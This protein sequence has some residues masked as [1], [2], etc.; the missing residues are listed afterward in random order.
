MVQL[1]VRLADLPRTFGWSALAVMARHLPTGSATWRSL[2][3][4]E[5]PW[6]QGIKQTALLADLFDAVMALEHGLAQSRTKRK[7]QR[8]QPYP[9]PWARKHR[10]HFYGS[11]PIRVADFDAWYYNERGDG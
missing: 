3:P 2:H 11:D 1:G 7:I 6:T 4:D 10:E 5:A 8:P 9:R